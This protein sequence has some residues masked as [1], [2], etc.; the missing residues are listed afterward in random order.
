MNTYNIYVRMGQTWM[1]ITATGRDIV[2]AKS[3]AKRQYGNDIAFYQY[4]VA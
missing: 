4:N 3:M 1:W 2:H